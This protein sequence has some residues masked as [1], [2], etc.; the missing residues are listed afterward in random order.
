MFISKISRFCPQNRLKTEQNHHF[1]VLELF[2]EN[3]MFL[4][5]NLAF[6]VYKVLET[7]CFTK[8]KCFDTQTTNFQLKIIKIAKVRNFSCFLRRLPAQEQPVD[9]YRLISPNRQTL[10]ANETTGRAYRRDL[11]DSVSPGYLS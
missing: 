4:V 2:H 8:S 5:P 11:S 6:Y 10:P 7:C 3:P 1:C 9:F